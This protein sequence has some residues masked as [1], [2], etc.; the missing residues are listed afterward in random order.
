MYG[1]KDEKQ[2]RLEKIAD[3]VAQRPEG[4]TQ[5]DLAKA[6]NVQ[7]STILRDLAVLEELGVLLAEDESGRLT[8]FRQRE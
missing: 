7:R 8:L 3:L 5:A 4:L 1:S 2:Q 6:V